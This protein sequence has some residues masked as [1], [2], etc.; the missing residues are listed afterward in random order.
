[1]ELADSDPEWDARG[2]LERVLGMAAEKELLLDAVIAADLSKAERIWALRHNVSEANK[3]AGFTVSNDTSAPVARVADFV[4]NVEKRLGPTQ[5]ATTCYVGH[6]G[7]GN[8][9]V[10]VVL[11][12]D[13]HRS[14]DICEAAAAEI[15]LMV[16]EESVNLDGSISAEHGIGQM[17]V[18]RLER[19]KPPLD[20]E[21][22]RRV[23]AVFDP[24]GIMNPGK[25]F[26]ATVKQ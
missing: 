5:G 9:H 8:V 26:A 25:I 16:H 24:A 2:Q 12:R 7:D 11:S 13:V 19:F 18:Q 1:M 10:V 17:H 21:L 23:R 3:V 4:A 22:M 14:K 6:I 20:L 15:N